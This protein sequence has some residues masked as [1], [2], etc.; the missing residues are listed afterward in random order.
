MYLCDSSISFCI[1]ILPLYFCVVD[2][3]IN[4]IYLSILLF[5]KTTNVH[6]CVSVWYPQKPECV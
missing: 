1:A 5:F 2:H 4:T 3:C 6:V